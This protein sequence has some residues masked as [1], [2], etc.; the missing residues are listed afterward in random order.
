M[1]GADRLSAMNNYANTH[2]SMYANGGIIKP[3]RGYNSGSSNGSSTFTFGGG[4][5][6]TRGSDRLRIEPVKV[7]I[8]GTIKLDLGGQTTDISADKLLKNEKFV[9]ELSHKL[10]TEIRRHWNA[11]ANPVVRGADNI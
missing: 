8:S 10:E 6:G 4:H 1:W 5:S 11:G 2:N 9:R 7:D 3:W